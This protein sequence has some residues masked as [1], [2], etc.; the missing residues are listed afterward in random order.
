V[1]LLLDTHAYL[2]FIAGSDALSL[3][4]RSVIEDQKNRKFIST[5][6]LWEI[7]IKHGLGKLDLKSGLQRV[8]SDHIANNGF[9]VLPIA[10]NHLMG[11]HS[12]PD[13]HRDPFDRLLIAQAQTEHMVLLSKDTKFSAYDVQTI[14]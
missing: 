8:L 13:H 3:T 7:T 11:L 12:L 1:D 6:S 9:E 5:G 14:W 2:W 10:T 4:G